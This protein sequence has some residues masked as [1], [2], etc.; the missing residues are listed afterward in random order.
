MLAIRLKLSDMP[1]HADWPHM[2]G[3]ALLCGIGFT[4]SIFIALLAFP[5][6]LLLQSE[7]KI[8]VLAGSLLAGLSGYLILRFARPARMAAQPSASGASSA[9]AD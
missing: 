4:M 1:A 6:D 2:L 3:V 8:G 5:G 9:N 7:A